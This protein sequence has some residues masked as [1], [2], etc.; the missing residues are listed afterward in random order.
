[1]PDAQIVHVEIPTGNPL[2]IDLDAGLKPVAVRY[3]DESRA[4]KLPPIA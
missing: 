1:V 3:L 4:E 2:V